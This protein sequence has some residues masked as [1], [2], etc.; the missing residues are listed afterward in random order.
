MGVGGAM[1]TLTPCWLA[2]NADAHCQIEIQ[3]VV[4][5]LGV[6]GA[7]EDAVLCVALHP[8]LGCAVLVLVLGV[9]MGMG[10]AQR[11]C[12]LRQQTDQTLRQPNRCQQRWLWAN[13]A[14]R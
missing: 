1:V 13:L 5:E 9:R 4:E 10:M 7:V 3:N 14:V 8:H 2:T 6:R 12:Q 11:Q